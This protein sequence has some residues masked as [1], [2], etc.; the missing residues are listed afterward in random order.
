VYP[1]S[2]VGIFPDLPSCH[3][4]EN[5][6]ETPDIEGLELKP[7]L[8]DGAKLNDEALAGFPS[9]HNL[10]YEGLLVQG[11]GINVFQSESRNPSMIVTLLET[12]ARA[13]VA[14]SKARLGKK[15]FVG[16]PF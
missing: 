5:I 2:L 7:G 15:C 16:Y 11:Y 9:M 6:F 4:E 8:V 13:N 14:Y 10:P 1:S 12:E 3:C